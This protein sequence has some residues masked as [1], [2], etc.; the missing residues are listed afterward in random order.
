MPREVFMD[1]G[2]TLR[3]KD[4]VVAIAAN[5]RTCRCKAVR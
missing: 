4:E 5:Y 3:D 2:I 1:N